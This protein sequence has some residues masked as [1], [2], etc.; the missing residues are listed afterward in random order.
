[1]VERIKEKF[2]GL[3]MAKDAKKR[4]YWCTYQVHGVVMDWD[5]PRTFVWRCKDLADPFA[6][7]VGISAAHQ[8]SRDVFDAEIFYSTAPDEN[9]QRQSQEDQQEN[10]LARPPKRSWSI[11]SL[12]TYP[13]VD[14][15]QKPFCASNHEPIQQGIPVKIPYVIKRYTRNE[16]YFNESRAF[17]MAWATDSTKKIL[18]TKF[19]GG[20][21]LLDKGSRVSYVEVQYEFWCLGSGSIKWEERRLDAGSFWLAPTGPGGSYQPAFLSDHDGVKA[22][23]TG[24]ILL[25]GNGG[26]LAVGGTPVWNVFRTY[27]IANLH[28]LG[29]PGI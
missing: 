3:R 28:S 5:F 13:Q 17:A 26:K 1:M 6:R 23:A 14:L 4:E 21:Q 20:E 9:T 19:D 7:M 29:L 15:D 8:V 25:N 10:P 2:D 27:P 22:Y 12:E 11:G 24:S 16:V 18:C